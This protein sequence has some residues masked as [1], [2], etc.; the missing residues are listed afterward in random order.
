MPAGS[1]RR[2]LPTGGASV[3]GAT[4]AAAPEALV[5][6]WVDAFDARDVEGMLVCLDPDVRFH[7]LRL[8]G[9]DR[10]YRGSG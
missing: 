3:S 10:S 2:P 4:I 9:L 5:T 6:R 8:D 1:R 7:P